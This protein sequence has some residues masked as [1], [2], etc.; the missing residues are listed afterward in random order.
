MIRPIR[1]ASDAW[2]ARHRGTHARHP[3]FG[4]HRHPYLVNIVHAAAEAATGDEKPSLLDYGCG[5]GVFLREMERS[6]R[7]RFARGF[8]PARPAFQ[9]RPS[10]RY[11]IVLC[12]DVLDQVETEFVDAVIADVAQ[13][14][15]G[16]AI[17]DVIT[18]QVAALTHLAP[19][20]AAAWCDAIS[21][22][23]RI[24]DCTIRGASAEELENGACPERAIV[25]A[26]PRPPAGPGRLS[27]DR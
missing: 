1:T 23:M 11:D 13:L 10:Q 6:G 19:R 27:P 7:F 25:A 9:T 8:D 5:K 14:T 12:L 17:F 15:A 24:L 18:V 22:Q 20:S 21:R 2:L 3:E 26:A 4:T 16:T